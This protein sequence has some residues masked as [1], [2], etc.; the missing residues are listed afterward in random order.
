MIVLFCVLSNFK[1]EIGK[2][3]KTHLKAL[4]SEIRV[5]RNDFKTKKQTN[6]EKLQIIYF[7]HLW[8]K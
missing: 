6:I 5:L 2:Y 3:T 8:L 4:R 7:N 1:E